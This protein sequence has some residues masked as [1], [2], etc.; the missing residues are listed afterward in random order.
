LIYEKGTS[1]GSVTVEV[2]F[3]LDPTGKDFPEIKA[4]NTLG[5]LSV[6]PK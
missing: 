2:I 6:E 3:S 5:K 4:P 1:A